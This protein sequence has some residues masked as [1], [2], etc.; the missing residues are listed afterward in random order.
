MTS[1]P[2]P[3]ECAEVR[4]RLAEGDASRQMLDHLADC[5]GCSAFAAGLVELEARLARLPRPEPPTGAAD[6]AIARFHAEFAAHGTPGAAPDAAP[7][8][9]ESLS[10]TAPV[11]PPPSPSAGT[12]PPSR[13]PAERARHASRA[14]GRRWRSPASVAAGVAAAIALVVALVVVLG[15]AS[16]P[17][18]YAAIL[19]EAAVHTGAKK[20]ARFNLTGA[21]DFSVRGQQVATA[22][23]G[24]GAT[25]FPDRGELTEVATILGTP[26]TQNIVS[27][28]TRTWTRVNG[29]QWALVPVPADHTS[30]IDQALANPAEALNAL[31][32]VGSGYRALGTTT[33]NGTRVRQIQLTIPGDSFHAFGSL[34]EQVSRW[35]VVAD[36]SQANL[37]LYR[38]GIHGSGR[39]SVLGIGVPFTYSLNLNLYDFDARGISIHPPP[40]SPGLAPAATPKPGSTGSPTTTPTASTGP[41]AAPSRSTPTPSPSRSP[42]PGPTPTPTSSCS[43]T[44]AAI[45]G[46]PRKNC[47]APVSTAL[48]RAS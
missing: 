23:R 42:S 13:P 19:H 39:V 10:A 11:T 17:P 27:V 21:V 6:R 26:L 14:R 46:S 47:S 7:A 12:A 43:A 33:V 29:G 20:S 8:A 9:A 28:G 32:R 31:T 44:A 18:A 41:S 36:V 25:V 3:A 30:P 45:A 48:S 15:P 37:V 34:P 35:I 22:I 38:L 2:L 5:E 4:R 1:E 40:G 16:T 24:T